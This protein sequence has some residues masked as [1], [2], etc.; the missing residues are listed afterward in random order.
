VGL[1]EA[2]GC[3]A[4][5]IPGDLKRFQRHIDPVWIDEA[6]EATGT[7]TVRR[8]R[9]PADQVVWMVVGM[10]L[11]RNDA[12]ERVVDCLDLALP[13]RDGVVAKSA[14]A[15]ARQRLGDE[16][17]AYLFA[18]TAAAWAVKSAE[19]HRWR[20]LALYGAD[21]TTL[22]VADTAEN[23]EA[24]GGQNAGPDKG[25]SGYPMVRILALMALRSHMLSAVRF[26]DYRTGEVTLFDE[27]WRELP[28]DSLTIVDRNFLV[29]DHLTRLARSGTNRHWL[30][31]AKSTTRLKTVRRLGKRDE[32]VEIELSDQTRR[33]HPN[34]P[35]VW[36]ARAITYQRKGFAPS[37]VLTSL[38]DPVQYPASEIV[39]LY[40]ERWEIELG[41]DEIK[42]H[43]LAR[44][45]T[46]RSKTVTGVRQE[47]WGIAIAYNLVRLEMERAADEAKVEPTRISFV[48]ALSLV[49]REWERANAPR[50]A[51]G[52]IPRDLATLRLNLKRLILPPRRSERSFPRAV[53]IK[54]SNYAR[55]RPTAGA[56]K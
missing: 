50:A 9:L 40:H 45:E 20:G 11:L 39:A 34:L 14:I 28:D 52:N 17:M 36:Q 1:D 48:Y 15:Q 4:D 51:I 41:Y 5:V 29:A 26:A 12:I 30:T 6:L 18:A 47:I 33:A 38:L 49:C 53:K 13:G 31:R 35:S 2:F 25:E 3:I 32:L 19:R 37:V 10:A 21:G 8:R 46:I 27:L 54:M 55:K 42:T 16:P 44:Q 56:A 24:F 22:R 23:R 7:A 43:M